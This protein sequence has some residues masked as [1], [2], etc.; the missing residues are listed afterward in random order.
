MQK[1]L[2][3]ARKRNPYPVD[4]F[5]EPTKEEYIE[6]QELFKREGIVQDKFFGA[7]GRKV[8]NNCIDKIDQL[9]KEQEREHFKDKTLQKEFQEA[10]NKY[11][12]NKR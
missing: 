11:Y 6:V 7:Y 9:I 12:N 1:L 3:D 8:W 5:L 2:E 4:I 10:Y